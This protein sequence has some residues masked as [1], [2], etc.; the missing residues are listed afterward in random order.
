M[1]YRIE[2]RQELNTLDL[3][4]PKSVMDELLRCTAYPTEGIA[5]IAEGREDIAE[6]RETVDYTHHPCEWVNRLNG[7]WLSALYVIN[8]S[9][10]VTLLIPADI[11]PDIILQELED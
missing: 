2:T 7:G 10:T 6:V 9:F 11:A 4:F 3:R 5:L 1:L 8:N